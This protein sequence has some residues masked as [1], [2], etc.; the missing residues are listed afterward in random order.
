MAS[1]AASVAAAAAASVAAAAAA[2]APATRRRVTVAVAHMC[3]KSSIAE[4]QRVVRDLA[5]AAVAKG[6][7]VLFLPECFNFFGDERV[8]GA[9]VLQPLG[10]PA[11]AAYRDIARAH[12]LW[13]SLGGFQ[14]ASPLAG[15]GHN[16]H[17]V[18]DGGGRL[19][20]VYRKAHL[21]DV[22]LPGGLRLK[23][24][25]STAAGDAL[26]VVDT[27]AGRLGLSVCY[28]VRFPEL[29]R[30]LAGAGAQVLAVP[31][32]FTVPTGA[33]HWELLLRA[34][35]VENQCYVVAAAQV[36]PHN[37]TRTSYGHALVVDPWGTVV[38]QA[39]G[40]ESAGTTAPCIVTADVDLDFLDDVRARM[41]VS[42]HAR[43][44]LYASRVLVGR[45][46][47]PP[48][49][50][51]DGVSSGSGGEA[52][53]PPATGNVVEPAADSSNSVR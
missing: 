53:A 19:A 32:A 8:S 9:Q 20:A 50:D 11:I 2:A 7:V 34:R 14:E 26:A 12:G 23:E 27:P 3:S 31:A 24:S 17:V 46:S 6:A 52:L 45:E 38:A 21:F 43:P 22:E 48:G 35:A 29:Y 40:P 13:L 4:N 49:T 44:A 5:A 16:A 10:G 47:V 36:G 39:G 41:P 25:D 28:D 33:A 18:I 30:A 51:D 1:S 42:A 15:K 37:G